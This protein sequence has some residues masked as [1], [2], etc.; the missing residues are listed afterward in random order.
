MPDAAVAPAS[1]PV[2]TPPPAAAIEKFAVSAI[3]R[4][5]T[6]GA[7]PVAWKDL[8]RSKLNPRKHFDPAALQDL[9]RSIADQGI[10]QN[11]VAR[12]NA[13]KAGGFEIAAG[14]RRHRAVEILIQAG[15]LDE[16]FY[17]P[18]QV[19]DLTDAQL[20]ELALA[21]NVGRNDLAPMEEAEAFAQLVKLGQGTDDIADA[22]GRTRRYVQ[23]R[24]DLLKRLAPKAQEA[25][26]AGDITV[27]QARALTL[28]AP[29]LQAQLLGRINGEGWGALHTAD[30]I[31]EAVTEDMVPVQQAAF[32]RS[33]YKGEIIADEESGKEYFADVAEFERLQEKAVKDKAA[34]LGKKWKWV[35]TVDHIDRNYLPYGYV[36]EP[37]NP[38]AGALVGIDENNGKL[39][40][41][42]GVVKEGDREAKRD[43]KK[44]K[45]EPVE[46]TSAFKTQCHL[47]RTLALREAVAG[48]PLTALRCVCAALLGERDTVHIHGQDPSARGTLP[49]DDAKEPALD[50]AAAPWRKLLADCNG[51]DHGDYG[52][53]G[54]LLGG[55]D[56]NVW[57]VLAKLDQK[58]LLEL[59]AL[60][61]AQRIGDFDY[62]VGAHPAAIAIAKSAA[63]EMPKIWRITEEFLEPCRK[64]QLLRILS[65]LGVKQV[66]GKSVDGMTGTQQ[67][68]AILALG[69]KL[70]GYVPPWVRFIAT[71]VIEEDT[72]P[73]PV[74]AATKPVATKP[75]A[76]A[77]AKKK[78]K[79]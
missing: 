44:T 60:L 4:Q 16:N 29:K 22:V 31:R 67:R 9:A 10:L 70:K 26:R 59:L 33:T 49:L 55:A 36:K 30:A 72:K 61:T 64:A 3:A 56:E 52:E 73:A 24:L 74:K 48:D 40:V 79:R 43:T 7:M 27:E 78:A 39:V 18:V 34:E 32:D 23:L 68:K 19:R 15:A 53:Q 37:K 14:E 42:E 71:E 8:H 2:K 54:I 50:A 45:P 58:K 63:L 5:K 6:A 12:K 11:L 35:E 21:E 65:D 66:D 46:L 28:G 13:A 69:D 77:P 38:K 20:L 17:L 57:P 25:L 75:P 1:K 62:D 51:D 76:K 47:A 41:V